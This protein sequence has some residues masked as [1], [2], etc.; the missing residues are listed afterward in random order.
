[1]KFYGFGYV[2][3]GG[4]FIKNSSIGFLLAFCTFN[5]IGITKNFMYIYMK[6]KFIF[7]HIFFSSFYFILHPLR[8]IW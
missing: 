3:D 6:I 2:T 1:M 4:R 7:L 5:S 8:T